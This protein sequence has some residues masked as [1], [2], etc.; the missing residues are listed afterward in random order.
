MAGDTERRV[1]AAGVDATV[2]AELCEQ[3]T[4]APKAVAAGSYQEAL[5]DL[6]DGALNAFL[7]KDVSALE[8]IGAFAEEVI[9]KAGD[10]YVKARGAEIRRRAQSYRCRSWR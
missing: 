10:A 7:L 3:R 1:T 4:R 5:D 2:A 6:G 9:E 8:E